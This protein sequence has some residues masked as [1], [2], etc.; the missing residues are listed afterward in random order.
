MGKILVIFCMV[1]ITSKFF[2]CVHYIVIFC[3]G[4]T[5]TFFLYG[6]FLCVRIHSNFFVWEKTLVIFCMVYYVIFFC[7]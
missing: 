2:V 1:K 5:L 3:V 7:V 4:K 6:N